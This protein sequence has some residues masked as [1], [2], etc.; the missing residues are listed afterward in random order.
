MFF[1]PNILSCIIRLSFR[2]IDLDNFL[3]YYQF[4]S[5][6]IQKFLPNLLFDFS[7]NLDQNRVIFDSVDLSMSS[8]FKSMKTPNISPQFIVQFDRISKNTSKIF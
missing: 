2:I 3:F 8:L 4:L 1:L 5:L 7:T 6:R